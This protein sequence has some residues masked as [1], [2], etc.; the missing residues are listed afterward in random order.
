MTAAGPSATIRARE[1]AVAKRPT[2]KS[3]KFVMRN[4]PGAM[5][6]ASYRFDAET[7]ARL[8]AVGEALVAQG[9]P[10]ASRGGLV[11]A[12]VLA[13]LDALEAKLGIKR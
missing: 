13:G 2:S 10:R 8:D 6:A 5:T 11:R 12:A 7:L 1:L 9:L 4:A 3:S